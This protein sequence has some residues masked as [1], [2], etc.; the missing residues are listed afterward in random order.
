L[1]QATGCQFSKSPNRARE[2]IKESIQSLINTI[3]GKI[4]PSLRKIV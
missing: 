2:G 4:G 1:K 3:I